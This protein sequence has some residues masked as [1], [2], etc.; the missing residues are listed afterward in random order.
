MNWPGLDN[1]LIT[2]GVTLFLS[3]F[4]YVAG[5]IV[6]LW[7]GPPSGTPVAMGGGGYFDFQDPRFSIF[8]GKFKDFLPIVQNIYSIQLQLLKCIY[9]TKIESV[10]L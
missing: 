8:Y 1:L 2:V 3:C 7:G 10:G 6:L 4:C 9:D 5:C